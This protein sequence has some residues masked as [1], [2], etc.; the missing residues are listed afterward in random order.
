MVISIVVDCLTIEVAM[1]MI[2]LV[3]VMIAYSDGAALCHTRNYLLTQ[4]Q[5]SP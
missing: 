2:V 5:P 1:V 4:R 3:I